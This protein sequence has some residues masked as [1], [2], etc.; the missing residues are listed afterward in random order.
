M[1]KAGDFLCHFG[2][3]GVAQDVASKYALGFAVIH[4]G[5]FISALLSSILIKISTD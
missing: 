5:Y 4:P 1:K 2:I 3:F